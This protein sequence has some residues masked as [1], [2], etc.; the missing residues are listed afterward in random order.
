MIISFSGVIFTDL[1][2][3]PL[4]ALNSRWE[5]SQNGMLPLS[6]Q[7]HILYVLF[8]LSLISISDLPV[9]EALYRYKVHQNDGLAKKYAKRNAQPFLY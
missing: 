6:P 2:T 7:L 9:Y 3:M 1:Y 8:A 5:L 4:A